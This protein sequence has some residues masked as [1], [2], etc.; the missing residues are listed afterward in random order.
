LEK[1][2]ADANVKSAATLDKDIR[3]LVQVGGSDNQNY[4]AFSKLLADR[5]KLLDKEKNRHKWEVLESL[6]S[7]AAKGGP[8]IAFG[9][10]LTRAG[11][12]YY[13]DP[14]N[15]FRGVARSAVVNEVSWGNWMLDV[16]QKG[17]RDEI[18]NFRQ[19]KIAPADAPFSLKNTDLVQL[20]NTLK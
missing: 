15:A 18:Y 20:E 16:V 1:A 2:L 5:Q 4:T 7:Y 13:T 3:S 17:T 10:M 14:V 11:Y 9:T 19:G 8:Q 12:K 6:A